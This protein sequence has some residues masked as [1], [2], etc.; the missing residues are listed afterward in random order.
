MLSIFLYA[1]GTRDVNDEIWRPFHTPY[2]QTGGAV[3]DSPQKGESSLR[4]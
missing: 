2:E 3:L 1:K 4:R